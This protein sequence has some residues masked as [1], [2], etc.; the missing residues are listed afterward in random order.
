MVE[1]G[2]RFVLL[3]LVAVVMLMSACAQARPNMIAN[4]VFEEGAIGALPGWQSCGGEGVALDD[5]IFYSGR[6]SL[7]VSTPGGM[8][9]ELIPYHGGRIKVSG[10]MRTENVLTGPSAPWH[11]AA[12]QI[13]SYDSDSKPVGHFDV[14]L[15]DGTRDWTRYEA[16]ELFSR[17]VA[18]IAV[19]CI[20]WG[21][22]TKGTVWFDDIEAEMLDSPESLQRRPLDLAKATL[23]VRFSKKM[24][25]FRHLW[26]GSDV[27]YMDRVATPTQ[28]NAMRH[29]RRFG[30]RYIRMHDCI[31][32]PDIYSEDSA[33]NPVFKW[34]T[35]DHNVR[36]VVDNGLWPVVVL[37]TMP[38]KIAAKNGG[39][40]WTNPYPPKGPKEYF[41]WQRICHELVRHCRERWGDD[42]RN[43]YF[44]VWNEPDASG[45]FQG[46]LQEYLRIYDHA[47][48]G[49]VSADPGIRIGGLG[50]AGTAWCRPFLEHC[51]SGRNDATTGA[52][53]RTD[54]LSWHIYT[55]GVGVPTF[56]KLTLSLSTVKGIIREFPRYRDLPLLITEWGCASSDHPVHDRPYDAAFRV[57]AV[58]E[59]MD[60]GVTLALPFSL[61]EGP[62]SCPR[63]VHGRSRALYQNDHPQAQ[64]PSVRVAASDGGQPGGMRK[65]QRPCGRHGLP[66]P[67]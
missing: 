18:F 41:K 66:F 55:V 27:S 21:P 52:G 24:G 46:T 58:R 53:C 11:K 32:D 17:E 62:A 40:N 31:H 36:A 49:A 16:T 54:F 63:R 64:L 29:A 67:G 4:G 60:S 25:E 28:I 45:Y 7:R 51:L 23:T 2:H 20:I 61:G 56:D 6:R 19:H 37:E 50:G 12:F 33:G 13:V 14:A 10:W 30:F 3:L 8:R 65:L 34:D 47:V 38:V 15:V 26:A 57:M 59:F 39:L 1:R 42:I 44:E 35:F 5:R 43:W 9:T 22:D 48:A